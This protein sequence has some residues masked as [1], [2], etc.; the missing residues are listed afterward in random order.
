MDKPRSDVDD[1][2]AV[3]TEILLKQIRSLILDSC[4][5]GRQFAF[6]ISLPCR[7]LKQTKGQERIISC[8]DGIEV[9][10]VL[11]HR[12]HDVDLRNGHVGRA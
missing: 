9:P 3:L 2:E 10:L 8:V 1:V 12:D 5:Q 11:C 7:P 6:G 4:Q